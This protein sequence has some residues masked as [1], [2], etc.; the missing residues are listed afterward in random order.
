MRETILF[1]ISPAKGHLNAS[2]GLARLFAK[3]EYSVVYALPFQL[4]SHVAEQGF[5]CVP[6]EGLPFGLNAEDTLDYLSRS[7]GG[8]SQRV[9][10]FDNLIDRFYDTIY[11]A[12]KTAIERVLQQ[13]KPNVVLLDSFQSTD[14]VLLYP[15]LRQNRVKF[16]FV[17]TMLSFHQQ[18]QS[19]PLNCAV[20]PHENTNFGWYW[21]K[22]FWKRS[23]K[24]A[25]DSVIFLGKSS[26]QVIQAKAKE[27]Q[28]DAL[29]VLSFRQFARV[30]FAHIPEFV[31]APQALEFAQQKQPNQQY[32]GLMVDLNRKESESCPV[33][34]LLARLAPTQRIVYCSFGTLYADFGKKKDILHF[35]KVLLKTAI[36]FPE[37]TF[38]INLSESFVKLLDTAPA[39]VHFFEGVPQLTVLARSSLF[40]T[41]GGLNSIQESIALGVPM[42]VLPVDKRWDQPGNA[43]KVV[44]HGLGLNGDM[45]EENTE[46]LSI[47]INTLINQ[48]LYRERLLIF[49]DNVTSLGEEQLLDCLNEV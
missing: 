23:F 25:L 27:Q 24:N 49:K 47:K 37:T 21:Q 8:Q 15:F 11:K 12:R 6:L 31:V 18:P 38:V 9:K 43:A 5:E 40:I 3:R 36:E 41:H 44:Y 1:V 4:H 48:S 17:Q 7:I 35:F 33:F 2:F 28:L 45:A 42:L 26:K 14:F 46:S 10:Y 16:A 30:G 39:N 20:V 29:Y 32:L 13:T 22:H 34:L 19:L